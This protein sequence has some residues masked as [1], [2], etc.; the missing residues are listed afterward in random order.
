MPTT[1][2]AGCRTGDGSAGPPLSCAG[3]PSCARITEPMRTPLSWASV[4]DASTSPGSD[5]GHPPG[6]ERHHPRQLPWRHFVNQGVLSIDRLPA[7]RAAKPAADG[8]EHRRHRC[9]MRQPVQLGERFPAVHDDVV[10]VP[11]RELRE[12]SRRPSSGCRR[13]HDEPA[14]HGDEHAE[15]QPRLPVLPEPAA[16]HHE[17]SPHYNLSPGKPPLRSLAHSARSAR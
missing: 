3:L 7:G 12:G 6:E 11:G 10:T 5:C 15:R 9:G 13:G 17:D 8:H 2:S 1:R 14:S 16:E 4:K